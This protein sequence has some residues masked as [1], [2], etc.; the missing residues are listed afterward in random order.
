MEKEVNNTSGTK[1]IIFLIY[2]TIY[3]I[4]KIC[5]NLLETFII[6]DLFCFKIN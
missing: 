4:I 2:F 5:K 1:N 6:I 3:N